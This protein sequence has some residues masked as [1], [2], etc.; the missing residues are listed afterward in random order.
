MILRLVEGEN[1]VHEPY[2]R[3]FKY[4]ESMLR[5]NVPYR[6]EAALTGVVQCRVLP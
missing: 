3:F 1:K 5:I 2:C 6:R 4:A